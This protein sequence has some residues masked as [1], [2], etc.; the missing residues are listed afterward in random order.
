VSIGHV[1]MGQTDDKQY[2]QDCGY[3][4]NK[5]KEICQ[6]QKVITGV[7]ISKDAFNLQKK[8]KTRDCE[9]KNT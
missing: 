6:G 7:I 3:A 9:K 5:E 1:A 2:S 8:T 4:K